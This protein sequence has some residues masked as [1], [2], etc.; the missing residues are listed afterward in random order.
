M[1]ARV[2]LPMVKS[3]SANMTSTIGDKISYSLLAL[4]FV[5]HVKNPA[6]RNDILI[7]YCYFCQAS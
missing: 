1:R 3:R 6:M 4:K 7:F 2:G 5:H